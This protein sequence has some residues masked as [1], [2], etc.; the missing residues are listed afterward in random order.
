MCPLILNNQEAVVICPLI[1]KYLYK[2]LT[3]LQNHEIKGQVP[4]K[5]SLNVNLFL[6]SPLTSTLALVSA[7]HHT[8]TNM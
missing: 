5:L 6:K 4:N 2:L 1:L 8:Q 7:L 3:K